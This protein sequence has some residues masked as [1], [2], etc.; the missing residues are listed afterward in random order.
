MKVSSVAPY[1]LSIFFILQYACK[2]EEPE[3]IQPVY[4]DLYIDI[5]LPSYT[6]LNIVGSWVY[7]SGGAKGIIAYRKSNTDFM[8]YDR[9]CTYEPSKGNV[10]V[11]DSTN[12]FAENKA[13]G[14]MFLITDGS[15]YK[16]PASLPLKHYQTN[17]DGKT[18]HIY[19]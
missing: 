11:V 13:C 10:A 1:I 17:F 3:S 8:A 16:A 4:V 18:L 19:N 12:I 7:V 15:V 14:S 6:K 5:S 9:N 2:K